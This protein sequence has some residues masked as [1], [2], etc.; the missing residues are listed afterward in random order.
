MKLDFYYM[1]NSA[2]YPETFQVGFSATDN[3]TTSFTFGDEITASDEQWHLCSETIPA[4]T[5]YICWKLNSY[6]QYCLYIDD[7]KVGTE[8][9]EWQTA[10]V[11]GNANEVSATLSG[12]MPETTYEAFAYP[13]CNPTKKSEIVNFT[14]GEACPIPT[15]FT[16][17]SLTSTTADLIWTAMPEVEDYTVEYRLYHHFS[18]IFSEG[19]EYGIDDWTLRNCTGNT[20]LTTEDAFSGSVGFF[21]DNNGTT[22]Y[23]ISPEL[24]GID[25][26]MTLR[27]YGRHC[28]HDNYE[29]VYVGFSAT[30][31]DNA[32]FNYVE[33]NIGAFGE[34][35]FIY[36]RVTVPAGTKYISFT[37]SEDNGCPL[38][39]D[40][41]SIGLNV[42]DGEWQYINVAGGTFQGNVTLTDLTPDTP[43]QAYVYNDCS[44]GSSRLLYFTTL[45]ACVTPTDLTVGD[46]SAITAN[47]SWTGG[48][49]VDSY[50][51]KYRT[52]SHISPVYSEGFEDGF[53][54]TGWTQ[55][56]IGTWN[57]TEGY[58]YNSIGTHSGS[59]N[60][61]INHTSTGNE[62]FLISP[63][64][65]LSGQNDLFLNFWY[66]N[67]NWGS[68]DIDQL[69][70]YYRVNEGGWTELWHTTE[71]HQ[72]WTESGAIALPNPSNGYQICFKMVDKWGHG[73]GIDDIAIGPIA[74][75]GEWQTI[76]VAGNTTEVSTPLTGLHPK[77]P[78]E[79]FVYPNCNSNKKSEIVRF[80][81]E[82]PCVTPDADLAVGTVSATTA[83]L[84]WTGVPEVESYTV[85]YRTPYLFDTIFSDGFENGLVDWTTYNCATYTGVTNTP[86]SG[87]CV[88][89]FWYN[90][91]PPQYL[92]SPELTGVT[93]GMKLEFYY[94]NESSNWPETFQ[95]GFS[96]TDNAPTSFTFG[97]EINVSDEQWHLH[98]MAIPA[99]AK[100]ICWKY[101]SY[102]KLGLFIDD[103]LVGKDTPAGEWQTVTVAG[104]TTE[105]STT[106]TGLTPDTP[107]EAYVY[108]D[109][110]PDGASETISFTTEAGSV[111][112]IAVAGYGTTDGKWHL[113]ALPVTNISPDNVEGMT[114]SDYDLYRFSPSD[115]DLE[116]RNY[117]AEDVSFNLEAGQGYLYARRN[118]ATLTFVGTPYSGNGEFAL[119]YDAND[120]HKCW[121]LVGNPFASE[122]RLNRQ[123]YVLK[124][125]GTGINP[126]AIQAN[127]PIPP[128]TAV[129][130]K[131]V[132]EGDKAV[133]NLVTQ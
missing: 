92:I 14:T 41:I 126:V 115:V 65:N 109:C 78:Y 39:I 21:F 9:S 80:T 121:N 128:F 77:T 60:V 114:T 129:F 67:Y 98:S 105:V 42:P 44:N 49:E 2:N 86:H 46:V 28:G 116:W 110:N 7:I 37:R 111:F 118:D 79:A 59:Y 130:V 5:K 119:N 45:E 107:Y 81:T 48:P 19:F 15:N 95:V 31:T 69:Y 124:A 76:N 30:N 113:I 32:S 20:G 54:P 17:D 83:S 35:E 52:S 106:L 51:M 88:F 34:W 63:M 89:K 23:L 90:T 82:E 103:I 131:A 93:S 62:T 71:D 53:M 112:S 1:N 84:S 18:P 36:D 11:E 127:T 68:S 91:N 27:F 4:G 64:L 117:K 70:V 43:Y 38:F 33:V 10:T 6:D 133:F 24:A 13:D 47:L 87:Y 61:R 72:V 104:G 123:Y 94:R 66:I 50:T 97:N 102:D 12:L 101:T 75:V 3:A 56:G 8:G 16:V 108:P 57:V 73:I 29:K 25:E 125:D 120:E 85:K 74:S 58:G 100:Y 99:G 96:W 40:D 26:E 122:A 132:A 55:S 22:Q